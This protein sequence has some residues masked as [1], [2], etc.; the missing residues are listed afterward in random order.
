MDRQ[1]D[2]VWGHLFISCIIDRILLDPW[3]LWEELLC[4]L[5]HQVPPLRRLHRMVLWNC[6]P[7]SHAS[8]SRNPEATRQIFSVG[9]FT[10]KKM[11]EIERNKTYF[12]YS[13]RSHILCVCAGLFLRGTASTS[14]EVFPT[15]AQGLTAKLSQPRRSAARSVESR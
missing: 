4:W 5:F 9:K 12:E 3:P 14:R 2:S 1:T 7:H 6:H 10:Q 8:P 15:A 11:L 13:T